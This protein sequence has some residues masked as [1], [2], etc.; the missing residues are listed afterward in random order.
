MPEYVSF[1]E[2]PWMFADLVYVTRKD[3]IIL[4]LKSLW[5]FNKLR[6]IK[7]DTFSE[8]G[9]VTMKGWEQHGVVYIVSK[10]ERHA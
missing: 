8:G 10:K 1:G 2:K 9:Q 7:I 4:A 5:P 3:R 6:A